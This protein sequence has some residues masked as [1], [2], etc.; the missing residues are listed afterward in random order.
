MELQ[1]Q[2]WL[3]WHVCRVLVNQGQ[4]I[5]VAGHLP[6]DPGGIRNHI[7]CAHDPLCTDAFPLQ[8]ANGRSIASSIQP[9]LAPW[10]QPPLPKWNAGA[11]MPSS[12]KN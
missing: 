10:L 4:G 2:P 1:Q 3:H 12:T 5:A 9:V 11:G 6:E 7:T 8:M